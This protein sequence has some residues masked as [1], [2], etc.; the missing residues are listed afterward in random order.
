MALIIFCY[1][2]YIEIFFFSYQTEN[3]KYFK[4]LALC[5]RKRNGEVQHKIVVMYNP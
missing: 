4:N 5:S 2:L 3:N 1:F